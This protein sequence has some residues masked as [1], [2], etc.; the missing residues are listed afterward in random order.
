MR[1]KWFSLTLRVDDNRI[2][3]TDDN[4]FRLIYDIHKNYK[5]KR[6]YEK[7]TINFP[8]RD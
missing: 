1:P 8:W 4:L 7:L 2:Y 5:G 6:R 3:L